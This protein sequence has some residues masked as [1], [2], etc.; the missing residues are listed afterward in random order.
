M[1]FQDRA[2]A[3]QQLATA[4]QGMDLARPVVLALV[5]G[6]APVA[7]EVARALGTDLDVLVVRKVGAP[8]N[9]EFG[10]G[11]VGERGHVVRNERAMGIAGV[12]GARF[13][14][15]AAREREEV[16]RRLTLYRGDR[17]G[18]SLADRTAVIVDDGLATG[19][20]ARAAVE[21]AAGLGAKKVVLAVPV[22]PP[23]TVTA[24]REVADEVVCLESPPDFRAVGSWYQDF[25]QVSDEEVAHILAG[26]DT[27]TG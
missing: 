21:V 17:P 15:L 7:A 11:A 10:V 8:G 4:L 26:F 12:D 3:G 22:G 1:P 27:A 19:V 16:D 5:R 23:D 6:G 9:P 13:E 25:T 20:S 2:D 14:E 18:V 24:L